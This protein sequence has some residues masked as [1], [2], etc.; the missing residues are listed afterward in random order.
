MG[1]PKALAA[2]K[3]NNLVEAEKNMSELFSQ[4]VKILF[5]IKIMAHCW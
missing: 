1:L 2:H 5:C 4:N 3:T